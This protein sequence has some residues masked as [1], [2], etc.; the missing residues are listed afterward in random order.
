MPII[1]PAPGQDLLRLAREEGVSPDDLQRCAQNGELFAC[2]DPKVLFSE[3][4]VFVPDREPKQEQ[5]A[6]G[7]TV[8]LVYCPPT[9]KLHLVLRDSTGALLDCDYTLQGFEYDGTEHEPLP[10]PLHGYAYRGVVDEEL[11]AAITKLELVINDEE[12]RKLVLEL[13]R[14]DPVSSIRGLKARLRNLGFYRGEIDDAF[15]PTLLE[16]CRGFQ[17]SRGLPV[18]GQPDVATCESLVKAHGI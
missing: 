2:R 16:A 8:H 3:D 1:K 18:T 15:D 17:L 6:A 14:L 4:E 11:P 9:R 7:S 5:A 13:G 12:D 10:G